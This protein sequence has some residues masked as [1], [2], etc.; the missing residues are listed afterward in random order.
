[1]VVRRRITS[2]R[3]AGSFEGGEGNAKR[4]GFNR[5]VNTRDSGGSL[6]TLTI[7]KRSLSSKASVHSPPESRNRL[8]KAE[9][10]KKSRPSEFAA[11]ANRREHS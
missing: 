10:E 5:S 3:K 7:L 6:P 2:S 11:N 8:K 9:G 1:M 4:E